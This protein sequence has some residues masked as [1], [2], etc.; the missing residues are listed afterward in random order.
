MRSWNISDIE[1]ESH[2]DLKKKKRNFMLQNLLKHV[3]L[4][5]DYHKPTSNFLMNLKVCLTEMT[6]KT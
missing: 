5:H 6:G 2:I 4:L 1:D 3:I